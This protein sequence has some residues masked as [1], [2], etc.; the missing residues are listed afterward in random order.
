MDSF[1]VVFSQSVVINFADPSAHGLASAFLSLGAVPGAACNRQGGVVGIRVFNIHYPRGASLGIY[2]AAAITM[3]RRCCVDL[4]SVWFIRVIHIV[5][6]VHVL[7][8]G[9]GSR[10][11]FRTSALNKRVLAQHITLAPIPSLHGSGA[12]VLI[13]P[14]KDQALSKDL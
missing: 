12:A 9:F 2:H 6:R 13:L 8:C 14:V 4:F 1:S 7:S 5:Q 10:L 3:N 11:C